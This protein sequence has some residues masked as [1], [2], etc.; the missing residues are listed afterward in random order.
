MYVLF[1][2]TKFIAEIIM[3]DSRRKRRHDPKDLKK[4]K[5]AK[6]RARRMTKDENLKMAI[7]R[8][9]VQMLE[10]PGADQVKSKS[11]VENLAGLTHSQSSSYL[12]KLWL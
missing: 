5:R 1:L 9:R 6:K 7:Y 2:S 10:R 3:E 8:D 12:R 11:Y 4:L